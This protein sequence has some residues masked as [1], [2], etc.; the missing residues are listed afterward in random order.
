MNI[1]IYSKDSCVQCTQAKFLMKQKC[2]EYDEYILGQDVT[3][4]D[5]QKRVLEAKST[6]AVRS[7]PQIFI[8]NEHIGEYKDLVAF[9]ATQEN[10][11]NN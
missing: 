4:Q 7:A 2:F 10:S 5:L 8:N 9:L 6:K 11:C 1:E 3:V